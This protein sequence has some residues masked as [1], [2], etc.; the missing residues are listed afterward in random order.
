M[1]E[2]WIL[3]MMILT[4]VMFWQYGSQHKAGP[5]LGIIVSI[6]FTIEMMWIAPTEFGFFCAFVF[7]VAMIIFNIRNLIRMN[8]SQQRFSQYPPIPPIH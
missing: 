1:N 2:F 7:G 4:L 3:V 6:L 8:D 5:I